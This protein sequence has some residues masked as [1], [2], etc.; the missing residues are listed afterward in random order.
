MWLILL[1]YIF[2]I[3]LIIGISVCVSLYIVERDKLKK[4][5]VGIVVS[6]KTNNLVICP[7]CKGERSLLVESLRTRQPFA[8]PPSSDVEIEPEFK[9]LPCKPCN[10]NGVVTREHRIKILKQIRKIGIEE[11]LKLIKQ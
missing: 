5:A 9:R 1:E 7:I 11:Y 2:H 3:A 8:G 10:G 6:R 4:G